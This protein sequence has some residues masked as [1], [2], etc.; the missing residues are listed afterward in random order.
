MGTY[1]VLREVLSSDPGDE[2]F[3]MQI[4][5]VSFK[6]LLQ[7]LCVHMK[8]FPTFSHAS[9][10]LSRFQFG[11]KSIKAESNDSFMRR[12]ASEESTSNQKFQSVPQP[13]REMVVPDHF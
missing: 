7:T 11:K 3:E 9:S 12:K 2:D 6:Y 10:T 5:L 13:Q 4:H 1:E 8:I